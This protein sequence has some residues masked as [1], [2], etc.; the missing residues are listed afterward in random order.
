MS[1]EKGVIYILT[2][3]SFPDYVKIG[4]AD[5]ID[6]RL[7]ELNRSECIPFAFRVYATYEV[8]SRL[9]D[10]KIH[11]IIDKLNPNLRS[12]D[13]F[14]GQKRVREFYAMSPEDAYSIFEAMAEIH[15]CPDK[16]KR[17]KPND[18]EEKAEKTAEEISSERSERLA[19]FTFS[20]CN[21]PMGAELELWA[22]ANT[23][24]GVVCTVVDDKHVKYED[25]VY[26]LTA[27]VQKV[28]DINYNVAGPRY[29]KYNGE[30]LNV[31][32]QNVEN[33]G[34]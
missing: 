18:E 13:N 19:P 30:W 9:S 1:E 24:T 29:F 10:L 5:D 20:L 28:L 3:P 32:R 8:T 31:I 11:S 21:I 23:N 22:S 27:L 25:E 33:R 26:S 14:N 15:N 7:K 16:L 34:I 4:Y 17:V 2:N 6:R 12:I